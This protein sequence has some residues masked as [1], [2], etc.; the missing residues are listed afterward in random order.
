MTR[1][2]QTAPAPLNLDAHWMAYTGNRQFKRDPRIIVAAQDVWYTDRDGRQILDG[3][4]GLW[5]S[6]LGHGRSEIAA[7]VAEQIVALDYSPAFQF[8]HPKA[9]ELADV[10]QGLKIQFTHPESGQK[11][12]GDTAG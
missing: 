8:G 5:T 10:V 7:A 11:T 1:Q 3:H 6:G 9:F 2:D 4:S 12:I